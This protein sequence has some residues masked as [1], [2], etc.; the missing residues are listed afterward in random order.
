M[1]ITGANFHGPAFRHVSA[2]AEGDLIPDIRLTQTERWEAH[3]KAIP[4][5][6]HH[7]RALFIQSINP[8]LSV[9]LAMRLM[10]TCTLTTGSDAVVALRDVG[11]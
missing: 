8:K 2:R 10:E 4:A 9:S 1:K 11:T 3:L 5:R 6:N 7:A